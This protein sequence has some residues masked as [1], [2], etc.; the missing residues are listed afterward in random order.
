MRDEAGYR[1]R[2]QS[3]ITILSAC[4]KNLSIWRNCAGQGTLEYALACGMIALAVIAAIPIYS[5]AINIVFRIVEA[6]LL[7]AIP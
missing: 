2:W 3:A 4:C 1:Q 7:A 6:T 5:N